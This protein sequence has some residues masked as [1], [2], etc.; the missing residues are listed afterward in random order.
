MNRIA[1]VVLF[2][3]I[4]LTFV[5]RTYAHHSAAAFDT[6]KEVRATG[7]VTEFAFR[8]PH[9]YLVLQV[10]KP[11][12]STG[13]LE[14]EAGA[15]SVLNPLG[16]TKTSLAVG[17]MV[18]VVG[19]PARAK[20]DALMLGKDLYKQDGAYYPLFIASRSVYAANTA[21]A[22]SIAGTWFPPF[23][24]F[25]AFGAAVRSWPV[26]DAGKAAMAS[27]DPKATAQ[28]DCIPVG[29]PNLMFYPV[30]DTITVQRDQQ[31][32]VMNIDWMDSQRVI[33]LDGRKHPPASQTFLHGHSVGHWEGDTLVVETTNFKD[34]PLG[35][36]TSGLP[37]STK[38]RVVERF[39]LAEGGKALAYSGVVEDPVY[40]TRPVEWSG[41][42]QYRPN[43]PHSNEKCDLTVAHKYLGDFK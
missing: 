35:L 36:S 39:R 41:Q 1:A 25:N 5:P 10:K 19:N 16:F 37:G 3:A 26:T 9:V 29:E 38:K 12:G 15:A 30:A 20:P 13:R 27:F 28:K 17:D 31:R 7:T 32:V 8:N 18:T 43:M 33:Y 6:Q 4:A 11:D 21:A 24:E 22:T 34:H 2:S 23:S 40:L 14:V 42:W